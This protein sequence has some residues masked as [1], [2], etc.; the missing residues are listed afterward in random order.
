[1]QFH[2]HIGLKTPGMKKTNTLLYPFPSLPLFRFLLYFPFLSLPPCFPLPSLSLLLLPHLPRITAH[3]ILEV[4]PDG[5]GFIRSENYLPGENDVYVA[6]RRNDHS[7]LPLS[8]RAHQIHNAHGNR[9]A[10][11]LQIQPFIG[12]SAVKIICQE[13]MTYMW[14]PARSGVLI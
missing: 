1:M 6:P 3:G 13:R 8:Y 7:P 12:I 4:M 5:F 11:R 10:R 2:S 14:L 9:G